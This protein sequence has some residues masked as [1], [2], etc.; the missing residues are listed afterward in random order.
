MSE[1]TNKNDL[2]DL[3]VIGMGPAG[4][5][6]AIQACREGLAVAI[7]G[8]EPEGGLLPAA[9]RIDNLAG[10][11][12]ISGRT[13]AGRLARQIATT[14]A[15]IF[16]HRVTAIGREGAYWRDLTVANG[17][18]ARTVCLATGT[19]PAPLPWDVTESVMVHRDIRTLDSD[20]AGLS[21]A[22]IGGGDAAFDSALTA[23]DR[24]ADVS[25]LVR[26]QRPMAVLNLIDEASSSGVTVRKG[27]EILGI[28][29]NDQGDLDI[30]TSSGSVVVD[31]VMACIGR[32]PRP[33]ILVDGSPLGGSW[34]GQEPHVPGVFWAGDVIR[35]QQRFVATAIGDGQM[36]AMKVAVLIA[37]LDRKDV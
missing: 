28:I 8:D 27:M 18:L 24:G 7:V 12:G 2:L 30:M 16:R 1:Q 20:L 9:R 13:L 10:S 4:I 6:C 29:E 31:R 5:S 26:G 37:E 33:E 15:V 23:R 36:V 3:L 17:I 35:G 22:V 25:I 34:M 32:L 11:P 14:N 19:E 21:V